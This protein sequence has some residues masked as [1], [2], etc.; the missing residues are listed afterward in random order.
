MATPL[1]LLRLATAL[2]MLVYASW[3]DLESR[4]V[5][6]LVWLIP[7]LV[8]VLASAIQYSTGGFNPWTAALN[9]AFM[10]LL[11][12]ASWWLGLFG[13]ADLLAFLSLAIIHPE[14]PRLPYL[15]HPP[16]IFSFTVIANTALL[17]ATM[18]LYTLAR[19]ASAALGGAQIFPGNL[20]TPRKAALMLTALNLPLNQV[21]G[22]PF[23]Y[24]LET[25]EGVR[26]RADIFDDEAA[27]REFQRLR[28]QGRE[29]VW[30]SA[31][32]PYLCFIT[33]GYLASITLGDILFTAF[34]ALHR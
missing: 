1:D 4:E 26:W 20:S 13:G 31:T 10:A 21:K 25:P 2:A 17:S 14:T 23:H 12:T 6:D 19:N 34:S 29:R 28:A 30:V 27:A 15:G 5:S 11:A 22:P 8:G 9:L 33:A 24:P 3:R 32:L 18:A 7:S 16:I